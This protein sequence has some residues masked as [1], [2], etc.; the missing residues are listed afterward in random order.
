MPGTAGTILA[1][2]LYYL[3]LPLPFVASLLLLTVMIIGGIWLCDRS[4]KALAV[5]DDGGI[6]FD[7]I[8]GFYA[9][10]L[11]LP[12]NLQWLAAGFVLF[13]ILDAAK[14]PPIGWLDRN[15][16]G[17]IGIMLDDLAAA[18]ATIAILNAVMFWL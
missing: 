7:E 1:V 3:T 5:K 16:S 9:V 18:A 8:T 11:F 10:L 12:Y 17:G 6:V 2:P 14:P 15:I 13:R 4:A